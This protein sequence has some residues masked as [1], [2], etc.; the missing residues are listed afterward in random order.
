L[1]GLTKEQLA[2]L[3]LHNIAL[4]RVFDSEGLSPIMYEPKMKSLGKLVA[5]NVTPC[6][7]AGHTLKTRSGHCPQCNP[8]YLEFQKRN[9]SPGVVYIAGTHTG[10]IIKV[11]FS[12]ALEVR[13][14]SI[15]RTKYANYD[16][17]TMLYAILSPV[18]GQIENEIKSKL[19]QYSSKFV[20]EHDGH[21]Q[22]AGETFTCSY[23]KVKAALVDLCKTKKYKIEVLRNINSNEFEF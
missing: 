19:S 4:D 2:F 21:I 12:K 16:D 6:R 8:A 7:N 20:Y 11:G 3:K 15:N 10:K 9:D 22:E 5:Y 14:E 1:K 17:W 18:A 23:S 13:D